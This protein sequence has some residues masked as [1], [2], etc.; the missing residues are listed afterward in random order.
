MRP[1]KLFTASAN[2]IVREVARLKPN[3][4]DT[5]IDQIIDILR[6]GESS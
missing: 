1:G 4:F 3:T 5:A 6:P 2:L